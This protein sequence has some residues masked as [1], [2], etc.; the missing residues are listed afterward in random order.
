MAKRKT[1][2]PGTAMK[3]E[4][5]CGNVFADLGLPDAAELATKMRLAAAINRQLQARRFTQAS[6]AAVLSIS[7]PN[8]SAL[9]HYK[10]D[11]FSAERLMTFLTALGSDIEIKI[12]PQTRKRAGRIIVEA[13]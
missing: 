11:S 13:V 2:K 9:K 7:Q 8:I 10:L 5:S 1:D 12:R 3:I 4:P 6:A